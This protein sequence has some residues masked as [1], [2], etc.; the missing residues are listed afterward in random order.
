MIERKETKIM[1]KYIKLN[2]AVQKL[3]FPSTP[4]NPQVEEYS[5]EDKILSDPKNLEHI[6]ELLC[7]PGCN[8]LV[9]ECGGGKTYSINAAIDDLLQDKNYETIVLFFIPTRVQAIQVG[10]DYT[11]ESIVMQKKPQENDNK[12]S[13]VYEKIA[14]IAQFCKEKRLE[15]DADVNP[16]KLPLRILNIVDEAHMLT[17]SLDFR[18]ATTELVEFVDSGIPNSTLML[19]GTPDAI[20]NFAFNKVV[21]FNNINKKKQF[22]K[23]NLIC[24]N[25]VI[26]T[27]GD[28]AIACKNPYIRLNSYDGIDALKSR[29]IEAGKASVSLTSAEKRTHAE[30]ETDEQGNR[31]M[32]Q[33]FNNEVLDS[34]IHHSDLMNDDK[35]ICATSMMDS[36]TNYTEYNPDTH[37]IFGIT[38]QLH[39]CLDDIEQAANRFRHGIKEG[40]IITRNIES[41]RVKHLT[42]QQQVFKILKIVERKITKVKQIHELLLDSDSTEQDI[43]DVIR[44]LFLITEDDYRFETHCYFNLQNVKSKDF[45]ITINYNQVYK[46]AYDLYSSSLYYHPEILKN[47]LEEVFG[48]SVDMQMLNEENSEDYETESTAPTLDEKEKERT[49]VVKAFSQLLDKYPSL[50]DDIEKKNSHPDLKELYSKCSEKDPESLKYIAEL[51]TDIG[52]GLYLDMKKLRIYGYTTPKTIDIIKMCKSQTQLNKFKQQAKRLSYLECREKYGLDNDSD[53]AFN[54]MILEKVIYDE[55]KNSLNQLGQKTISLSDDII[56]KIVK[57]MQDIDKKTS[58]LVVRRRIA[59]MYMLENVKTKQNRNATIKRIKKLQDLYRELKEDFAK[60][61]ADNT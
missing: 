15:W 29:F 39:S 19:T 28:E 18:Q 8:L 20:A 32:V 38:S 9:A 35:V 42:L 40:S 45:K 55:V 46:V 48:I 6:K 49:K 36:G 60:R 47:E 59:E 3:F 41:T 53:D 33:R 25:D 24:T 31:V 44:L 27:I 50:T 51:K 16:N 7:S 52:K 26:K 12:M 13:I 10:K 57:A 1:K 61:T 23:L 4:Y 2:R 22:D 17:T 5:Y 56:D 58:P 34:I 14:S 54:E 30:F 37:F 11:F 43:S 21:F